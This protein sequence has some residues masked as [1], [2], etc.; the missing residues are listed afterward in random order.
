MKS[1]LNS[2]EVDISVDT[3]EKIL[4]T[5]YIYIYIYTLLVYMWILTSMISGIESI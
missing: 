3:I 5:I 2:L 1:L 4:Y